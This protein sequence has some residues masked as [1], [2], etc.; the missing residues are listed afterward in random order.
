MW[1]GSFLRFFWK[2]IS[3]EN[4]Y[5][6]DV[7]PLA[8][9]ICNSTRVPG[10]L[11]LIKSDGNLPYSDNFFDVIIAYSVFT[12]LT[13]KMNLHWMRELAR[14]SK[15]GCVFVFTLEPRGFID[16]ICNV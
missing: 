6:C 11:N 2:D 3:P 16:R 13:E 10:N 1:L 5:G 14:V 15:P 4:L 8:I 9:D 7:L 12:H